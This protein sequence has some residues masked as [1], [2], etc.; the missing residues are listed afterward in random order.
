M[1]T[2]ERTGC[3]SSLDGRKGRDPKDRGRD[4]FLSVSEFSRLSFYHG[5]KINNWVCFVCSTKSILQNYNFTVSFGCMLPLFAVFTSQNYPIPMKRL[6]C[7]KYLQK[8]QYLKKCYIQRNE[9]KY[10]RE[11]K[12]RKCA[13]VYCAGVFSNLIF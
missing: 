8:L 2:Q 7:N 3:N 11:R 12:S 9:F 10:F 1:N 6:K 13:L 5:C 4:C